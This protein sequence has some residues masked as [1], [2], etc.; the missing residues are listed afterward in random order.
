MA[1]DRPVLFLQNILPHLD[2]KIGTDPEHKPVESRMMQIAKG[3]TVR[4]DGIP[5][6]LR[7]RNNMDRLK[8]FGMP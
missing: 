5:F 4:H 7:V 2:N 8:Q 1:Q 6:R 3:Y